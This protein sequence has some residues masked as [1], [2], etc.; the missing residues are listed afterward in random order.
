MNVSGRAAAV[1]PSATL[2]ISSRAK[3]MRAEGRD[4]I[5]FAIGE[6]D[7]N[8]PDHITAA[9]IDALRSGQT[10]YTPAA[11]LP[12]LRQA[13][14][15][16]LADVYGLTYSPEQVVV[17][18]GA[19]YALYNAFQVLINPGDEVIVPTPYWVT[20]PDQVR[21]AGGRPV[22]VQTDADD[23][24]RL[25]ADAVAEH[26]S[27]RT[28]V[29]L[30]NSPCN[31]TGAVYDRDE[32]AAIGRLAVERDV[33]IVS[34]EIY[35]QLIYD[36]AEH[37][38]PA[39]LDPDV[40]DRTVTINGF[41]KTY[42][43]TGW[44][45]GYAAAPIE[46]ARAMGRLQSQVTSNPTTFAQHG[47]IAALTGDQACVREMV[48]AFTERR[49][50]VVEGLNAIPGISC[51]TP[52]GAFYAL[53]D[54]SALFGREVA[55]ETVTDSLAFARIC[56]ERA[57]VAVIHGSAFGADRCVRLSYATGLENIER[58]LARL[59][60]LIVDGTTLA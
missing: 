27:D 39:G 47:A 52:Y 45:L 41:S 37:V 19:K 49:A 20:Y 18:C 32:V 34:D 50:I 31:P 55:G 25:R 30:L 16:H 46:I 17:S 11:G 24:F 29:I 5:S 40:H 1:Q 57:W 3:A 4:I 15:D 43:M 44:R 7:F 12:A 48:E 42:A 2:T 9:A 22:F 58:G 13:I 21:L 6:P 26:I 38:S 14:A 56:L 53:A 51:P 23:G 33:I 60:D 59:R 28:A 10:K 35:A 36:G 54:V 8:T